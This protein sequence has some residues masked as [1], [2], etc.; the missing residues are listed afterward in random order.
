M[1]PKWTI[2]LADLIEKQ[3]KSWSDG[4]L[5]WREI[6]CLIHEA[7][8]DHTPEERGKYYGEWTG[9]Y[10]TTEKFE[11]GEEVQR[12]TK[13]P[14][15]TTNEGDAIKLA[16]QLGAQEYELQ[17]V[18]GRGYGR[19]VAYKNGFAPDGKGYA[20]FPAAALCSAIIRLSLSEHMQ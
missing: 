9:E 20:E 2:E 1:K 16:L 8:T 3:P 5:Q 7:I 19:V 18:R 4:E 12:I 6:D 10:W 17:L 14:N 15:Y 11:S 13:A